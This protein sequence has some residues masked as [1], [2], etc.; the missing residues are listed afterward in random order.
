MTMKD[1]AVQD[2]PTGAEMASDRVKNMSMGDLLNWDGNLL[3]EDYITLPS[4][5][6]PSNRPS[7]RVK[8]CSLSSIEHDNI[9]KQ[10]TTKVNR[11]NRR[12]GVTE[13]SLDSELQRRLTIYNG[14]VEPNLNDSN[15]QRKFNAGGGDFTLIVDK[16]FLMGEQITLMDKILELSGITDEDEDTSDAPKENN[17]LTE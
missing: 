5:P 1:R 7:I 14:V 4:L 13:G 3:A 11:M 10:S 9:R 2:E 12:M 6:S 8:V 15:F 16:L 17:F